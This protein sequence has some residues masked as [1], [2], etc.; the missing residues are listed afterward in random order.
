MPSRDRVVLFDVDETLLD[1]VNAE[2]K[3][4]L[5][6]HA[7]F[8]AELNL[9][10]EEFAA[11]WHALAEKWFELYGKGKTTFEG[12]RRERLRAIFGALMSDSDADARFGTYIQIYERH[13]S[14][15]PDVLPCLEAL[16][17]RRLG[18]ITNGVTDQQN[19]KLRKLGIQA[20]FSEV[21]CSADVGVAKP[22]PAIF[23]LAAKRFQVQPGDCVYVGDRLETDALAAAKAGM[24]GVW[25]NRA[26]DQ[27]GEGIVTIRSLNA[28]P[29]FLAGRT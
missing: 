22:D 12:Q 21:L 18:I 5:D 26:N 20:C 11:Q 3:A 2:R 29:G 28:L 4:A 15:F 23:L 27:N 16:K 13:W 25:L 8:S 17:G 9:P 14:L 1:H 6:F 10:A 24:C 7:R 19:G